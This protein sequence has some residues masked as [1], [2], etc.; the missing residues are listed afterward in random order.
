MS[1]KADIVSGQVAAETTYAPV[2]AGNEV[3]STRLFNEAVQDGW[4]TEMDWLWLATK[5]NLDA[6][7]KYCLER[8][9]AINPQ[10]QM[11]RKALKTLKAKPGQPIIF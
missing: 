8:A 10:S 2:M 5:V 7:R 4:N 1:F 6:Q 3:D 9:L 11:A